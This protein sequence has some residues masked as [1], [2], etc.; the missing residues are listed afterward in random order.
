MSNKLKHDMVN[1]FI[2]IEL[3]FNKIIEN[4]DQSEKKIDLKDIDFLETFLDQLKS[5]LKIIK[6]TAVSD[7]HQ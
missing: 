1:N 5:E 6:A 3:L 4:I 7:N 2:R